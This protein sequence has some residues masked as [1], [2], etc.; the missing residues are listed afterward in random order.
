MVLFTDFQ[1]PY[2]REFALSVMPEITTRLV[3]PGFLRLVLMHL[4]NPRKHPQA[5]IAAEAV[6]CAGNQGAFWTFHDALFHLPPGHVDM[7][8]WAAETV[9]LPSRQEFQECLDG[10]MRGRV[11]DQSALAYNL[12]LTGTPTILLGTAGPGDVVNVTRRFT[13]IGQG[14]YRDIMEFVMT[15]TMPGPRGGND[16]P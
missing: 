15:V 13:G 8:A 12:A 16:V 7:V 4:P 3:A 11:A 5:L 10:S 6:E 14:L 9:I 2:C 1:C